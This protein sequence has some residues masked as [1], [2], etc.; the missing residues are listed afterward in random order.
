MI[1]AQKRKK[2]SCSEEVEQLSGNK[3]K[4]GIIE[5]WVDQKTPRLNP[6]V[7]AATSFTFNDMFWKICGVKNKKVDEKF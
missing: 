2:G 5:K 1:R 3:P 4:S 6:N 7:G